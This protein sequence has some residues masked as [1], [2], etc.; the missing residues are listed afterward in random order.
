MAYAVRLGGLQRVRF[1]CAEQQTRAALISLV[2]T[3]EWLSSQDCVATLAASEWQQRQHGV[4]PSAASLFIC[5]AAA[6]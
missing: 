1:V 5:S 6:L 2:S 4:G 3:A